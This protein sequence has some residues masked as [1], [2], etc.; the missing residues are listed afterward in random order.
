MALCSVISVTESSLS[1]IPSISL[2]SVILSK[3]SAS[4]F[5][6]SNSIATV[7]NSFKFSIL[8]SAC[9]VFS[10]SSAFIYPVLFNTSFVSSE[11]S[12]SSFLLDKSSIVFTNSLEFINTLFNPYC[13]VCFITSYI[14]IPFVSAI[15]SIF[16]ILVCPIP[17]FGS[18]II[19]PK[20]RLSAWLCINL[21]YAI[22]S[23]I[24]FL[25]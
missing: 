12:I 3:N 17:R 8:L 18:F 19:L 7:K 15:A 13:S 16:S 14:E 21:K 23:F 5:S 24:S 2:E 25:S 9:A 22:T 11:I 1:S 10:S 20:L 4:E 6:S